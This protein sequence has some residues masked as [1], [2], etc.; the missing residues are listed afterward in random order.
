MVTKKQN[1]N[2]QTSKINLA[3]NLIDSYIHKKI[4]KFP[5]SQI[6]IL[7][8]RKSTTCLLYSSIIIVLIN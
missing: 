5:K 6:I 2:K 7:V 1:K 8:I 4:Y 3:H